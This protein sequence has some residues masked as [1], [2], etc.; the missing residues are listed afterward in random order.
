MLSIDSDISTLWKAF[1]NKNDE[2][3]ILFY[4]Q[5]Y[6]KLCGYAINCGVNVESAQ[7]IVQEL[8]AK[9]YSKPFL[10]KNADTLQAFL[11]TSVRNATVNWLTYSSRNEN[12]QNM[13][14][15]NFDYTVE[16]TDVED[17]EERKVLK[18]KVDKVLRLLTPRQKEMIYLRFLHEME[19][20]EVAGIMGLSEQAAR[21]LTYRAI[22]K[23]RKEYK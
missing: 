15:F 8:F 12:V 4:K 23:I 3:F 22:K 5:Q 20:E 13:E 11:F 1:V 7:D 17:A 10:I 6:S 14:I 21:N 2:A 16:I 18:E 9:L 19:Y